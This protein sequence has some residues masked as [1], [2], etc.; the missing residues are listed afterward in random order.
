MSPGELARFVARF[1]A[2]LARLVWTVNQGGDVQA[3][4]AFRAQDRV[5]DGNPL[6]ARRALEPRG[7]ARDEATFRCSTSQ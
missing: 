7:H 6:L 1:V 2:R 3:A 4:G 5:S